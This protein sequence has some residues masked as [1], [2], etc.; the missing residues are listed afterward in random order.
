VWD[1][2]VDQS[3]SEYDFDPQAEGELIAAGRL[4]EASGAWTKVWKRFRE[5]PSEYPNLPDRLRQARPSQLFT[6][7]QGRWPQ[8]NEDAE[9][10]LRKALLETADLPPSKARARIQELWA[11][12]WHRL[13]WVWADLGRAPLVSALE[14]LVQLSERTIPLPS[15][16]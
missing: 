2:F 5:A 4:G 9:D 13:S 11:G 12:H 16:D 3:R 7:T 15:A 8:D 6:E 14:Q 10:R 1:A